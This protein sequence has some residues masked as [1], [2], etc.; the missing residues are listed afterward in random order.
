MKALIRPVRA[1]DWAAVASIFNHYVT[2]SFAAYP[3]RPVGDDFFRERAAVAPGYPFLVAEVDA[4]LVG[5][6]YLAPFL[7]VPTLRRSATLTYFLHPEHTGRGLGG[8]FLERLLEAGRHLGI[9]NFL[10]HISSANEGSIR[11]HLAHGFAECGRFRE[12]GEKHGRLFDM[13]WM[14]RLER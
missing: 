5:F 8:Q 9:V 13:I 14:Q 1:S 11:F 12:V 10:A 3:E 6:A 2:E 7:P 4:E